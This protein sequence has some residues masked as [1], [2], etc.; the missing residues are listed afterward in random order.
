MLFITFILDNKHY[1]KKKFIFSDYT[2]FIDSWRKNSSQKQFCESEEVRSG[3]R[4][5]TQ[6]LPP[7]KQM[8]HFTLLCSNAFTHLRLHWQFQQHKAYK[9][10][11]LKSFWKQ[12]QHSTNYP[13]YLYTY[14]GKKPCSELPGNPGRPGSPFAPGLPGNPGKPGFPAIPLLPGLPGY[15]GKPRSP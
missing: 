9:Q 8:G 13:L 6:L 2:I 12:K 10:Q 5:L 4:C 11:I 14:T 7:S 1:L 3:T 15:P